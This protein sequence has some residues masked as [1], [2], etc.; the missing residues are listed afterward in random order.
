MSIINKKEA[1]VLFLGDIVVFFVSLFITLYV[2]YGGNISEKIF[3]SHLASFSILFIVWVLIYF[4][5]GLYDKH[6]T[7]LK[8][9]LPA[10]LFNVGLVNTA[11]AVLFFYLIPYFDITPKTNLFVY[12]LFSFVLMLFW[13]LRGVEFFSTKRKHNALVIGSGK[14]M[15][16]LVSEVNGN[17]R[18]DLKFISS[19]DVENIE[20]IDFQEEILNRIYAEEISV[21]AVDLRNEKVT[22]ILPALYNLIFSR[23]QFIDM[24][25]LYEDI[26]D[27]VPLSL[28]KYSWFL[29][30]ISLTPKMAFDVPKRIMDIFLGGALAL[31]SLIIYP[32][33]IIAIKIEDGREIF[34]VQ[35]RVGR[36]N[37]EIKLFKFRSM[38][39]T[40]GGKWDGDGKENY[41]TKVGSFI[42]KTRIDE[43][44]QLWNVLMGDISLIG[45]RPEFAEA[46]KKYTEDIP[47]YNIRHLIKPGLSGWAQ[48]KHDK[49]P[50]HGTDTIETKNKLSYDLY[51]IKNR[52]FI[53]DLKIALQTIQIMLLVKG[54]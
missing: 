21:I 12:L 29:E 3:K 28:V 46:V 27:R 14:E 37:K 22:K 41:V 34:S 5:S 42:R 36:N 10:I 51:Y 4:I 47:Y 16:E 44:P 49:H 23:V 9:K 17:S 6:T 40:D 11:M 30:N 1:I 39:F 32:F 7:I 53:L 31:L 52:S 20:A 8:N 2:R 13:R 19:V 48:M 24:H 35:T 15:Q 43:L 26:F 45:P 38:A 50:H 33:V 18:Y 54:R 25:K